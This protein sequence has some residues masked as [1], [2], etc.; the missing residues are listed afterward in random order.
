MQI[1]APFDYARATSVADA[2]A[3]L[4]QHGPEARLI[5]GGHSLLPMMKLRLARPDW[6]IDINDLT[7]LGYIRARRRQLRIGALTRHAALLASAGGRPALPDRP[8]RRAGDRRPGGPQP[9]HASAA[10]SARPTRPRTSPRSATC[11]APRWSSRGRPASGPSPIARAAPRPVRD[12]G[13]AGRAAHRDPLPGPAALRQRLR[14]GG[15]PGRRLGGRRRRGGGRRWPRTATDRATPRIGLTAVGHRG[16]LG[17][18]RRTRC[19]GS[20]PDEDAVRRGRPARRRRTATRSRTSAARW[21]TSATS[22]TSSPAG[23][24]AGPAT[25]AGH[26]T[27]GQG[28]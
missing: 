11:S 12:R 6:L 21:T 13:R 17:A 24:C 18:A 10:R 7:E 22:P 4:R 2:L 15:A 14:E 9:R 25:R 20:G 28:G 23:S 19:A 5:A 3:L 16:R 1:P 8:R 26:R 27:G